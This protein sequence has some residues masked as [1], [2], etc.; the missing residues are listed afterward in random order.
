MREEDK[1]LAPVAA[2]AA[3]NA[4]LLVPGWGVLITSRYAYYVYMRGDPL[5]AC[6]PHVIHVTLVPNLEK[7]SSLAMRTTCL[8]VACPAYIAAPGRAPHQAGRCPHL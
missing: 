6:V 8:D 5:H 2:A 7:E 1:S 4:G 3:V